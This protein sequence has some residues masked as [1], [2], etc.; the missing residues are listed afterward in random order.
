VLGIVDQ[1]VEVVRPGQRGRRIVRGGEQLVALVATDVGREQEQVAV[2]TRGVGGQVAGADRLGEAGQRG[3][4]LGRQRQ[5]VAVGSRSSR[6][7][8][9]VPDRSEETS[10]LDPS[11]DQPLGAAVRISR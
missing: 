10:S 8:W 4:L 5:R 11:G 7:T 9:A 2:A 1:R 6:W 3:Q